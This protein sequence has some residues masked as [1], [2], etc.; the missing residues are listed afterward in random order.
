MPN[1]YHLVSFT[2]RDGL[3]DHE[4]IERFRR[5]RGLAVGK[6]YIKS[7]DDFSVGNVVIPAG[8]NDEVAR[9]R[10]T[11][12][13]GFTWVFSV[14]LDGRQGLDRFLKESLADIHAVN[15]MD[16]FPQPLKIMVQDHV[17]QLA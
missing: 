1:A 16:L 10:Q 13:G 2:V 5:Y 7:A 4:V 12:T 8:G 6:G 14:R 9:A 3:S 17:D 11:M 15:L